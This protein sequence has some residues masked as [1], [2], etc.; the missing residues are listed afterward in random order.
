MGYIRRRNELPY[1]IDMATE[2]VEFETWSFDD[3]L[4]RFMADAKQRGL[5]SDTIRYYKDKTAIFR[6]WLGEEK[7]DFISGVL[8]ADIDR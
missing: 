4:E 6:R 8:R 7:S 5:R 3:A 1:E 2:L